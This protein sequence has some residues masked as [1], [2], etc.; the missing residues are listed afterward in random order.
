M[1][2]RSSSSSCSLNAKEATPETHSPQEDLF[3]TESEDEPAVSRAESVREEE[4]TVAETAG[5]GRVQILPSQLEAPNPGFTE[6]GKVLPAEFELADALELKFAAEPVR[7]ET[8]DVTLFAPGE[9]LE[10]ETTPFDEDVFDEDATY[11]QGVVR[12]RHKEDGSLECNTRLVEWDDGTLS[13]YVEGKWYDLG[14]ESFTPGT[15]LL[16]MD[17][18]NCLQVTNKKE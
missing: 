17:H 5:D 15:E 3:G 9:L 7:H 12:W 11:A 16:C 13:L 1:A 8:R 18:Q 4:G 10:V 2:P 14:R 6:E